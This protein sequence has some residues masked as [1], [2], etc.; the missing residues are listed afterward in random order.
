LQDR[1]PFV[2]ETLGSLSI[3]KENPTLERTLYAL[4]DNSPLIDHFTARGIRPYC[5]FRPGRICVA[6]TSMHATK[7][8]IG[9]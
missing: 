3:R 5:D 9:M 6:A 8:P 1:V 4:A 2:S 7:K